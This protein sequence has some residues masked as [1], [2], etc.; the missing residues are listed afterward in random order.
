MSNLAIHVSGLS[1]QYRIGT[2]VIRYQTLRDNL[3]ERFKRRPREN[4]E[5]SNKF[6]ALKDVSLMWSRD[7]C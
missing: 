3:E 6:W 7:R 5:A 4:N 1:K 2:P